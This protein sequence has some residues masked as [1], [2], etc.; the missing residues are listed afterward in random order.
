MYTQH[1]VILDYMELSENEGQKGYPVLKKACKMSWYQLFKNTKESFVRKSVPIELDGT[2]KYPS[3]L[4]TLIGFLIVDSCGDL[5]PLYE[6][7]GKSILIK[8]KNKCSC[9]CC[10]DNDCLCPTIQD[11]FTQEDVVIN[12]VPYTNITVTRVLKNGNVIEETTSHVA[13]FATNG[14]FI[15]AI[16]IPSQ[17]LKC[18]LDVKPCGCPV[19]SEENA[20]KLLSCGCIIDCYAP[21]TREKYPALYNEFGYYKKEDENKKAH[22]FDR[23]GKKTK[24]TQVQ[25]VYQSNGFDILVPDYA[26]KA[27]MA[28]LDWTKK[29]YSPSFLQPQIDAAERHFNKEEFKMIKYLNPIPFEW[30]VQVADPFKK[31]SGP[32]YGRPHSD[33]VQPEV[34]TVCQPMPVQNITN[35]IQSDTPVIGKGKFKKVVGVGDGPV[36]GQSTYTHPDLI[37]LGNSSEGK[38]DIR[39]A[40]NDLYN[41]GTFPDFDFNPA[42]GEIALRN[43][44]IWQKDDPVIA[45]LN[46]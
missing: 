24:L 2:V 22:I 27:L 45:D 19:N 1:E 37:G 4:E 18:T 20:K 29:V 30:F 40:K 15:A 11:A 46:Q 42:T 17:T 32:Y 9:T 23:H 26:H 8:P 33:F 12:G 6:D 7:N 43:G 25:I 41:W 10:D 44:N 31:H 38:V 39:V 36:A 16:P 3:S 34:I 21:Y 28:L 35:I 14:D 13:S 5:A